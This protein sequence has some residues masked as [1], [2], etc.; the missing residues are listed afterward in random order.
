M[1]EK[2]TKNFKDLDSTLYKNVIN[3]DYIL[4]HI[5]Y[6][7]EIYNDNL[8]M[9][10]NTNHYFTFNESL[11][12]FY[13]TKDSQA[14]LTQYNI[15]SQSLES[16]YTILKSFFLNKE[17]FMDLNNKLL[18][19]LTE[20]DL[21]IE[22]FLQG[23][24]DEKCEKKYYLLKEGI[25]T[26]MFDLINYLNTSPYFIKKYQKLNDY[27]VYQLIVDIL[28]KLTENNTLLL[29]L[30]FNTHMYRLIFYFGEKISEKS[31]FL[32]SDS[33]NKLNLEGNYFDI[34]LKFYHTLLYK[35]RDEEIRLDLL[36]YVEYIINCQDH[37]N[38][39]YLINLV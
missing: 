38:V 18:V 6:L 5:I 10:S 21:Q 11:K 9:I 1:I 28:T 30:F 13:N 29:P 2:I 20:I 37:L 23:N 19:I 17:K 15:I 34:F 39:M 12:K 8:L 35:C 25:L 36:G 16:I 33:K 7:D 24:I 26:V 14:K 4:K 31:N 22:N 27:K 32:I 3:Y